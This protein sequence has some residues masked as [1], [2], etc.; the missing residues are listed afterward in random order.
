MTA[1]GTASPIRVLVLAPFPTVRAGLRAVVASDPAF[2][3]AGEAEQLDLLASELER[4]A[5]DVVLLDPGSDADSLLEAL[6]PIS[7]S[8]LMPPL[9]LIASSIDVVTDAIE[10]GIQG[11]LLPDAS[12]DEIGAALHAVLSGLTAIDNRMVATLLERRRLPETPP[13]AEGPYEALTPREREVL[14][15]IAQGL[16]NKTIAIELGISEHTVKFH[17]GSIL[18]KLEASSRAEALARAARVGLIVL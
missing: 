17:V 7:N 6:E 15:L 14:Q 4:L 5:P 3:V 1:G 11:L 18:T 8:S 2:E 9:V 10:G 13:S 12:P 16:P